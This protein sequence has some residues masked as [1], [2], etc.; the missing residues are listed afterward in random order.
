MF[1]LNSVDTLEDAP[2]ELPL[3]YH[4]WTFYAK[5]S[6]YSFGTSVN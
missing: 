6:L 1:P 3:F 4:V 5:Y 2:K